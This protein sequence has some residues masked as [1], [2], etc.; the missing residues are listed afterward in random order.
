MLVRNDSAEG[1]IACRSSDVED[2][3]ALVRLIPVWLTTQAY[4]IPYAQYMTS[5]TKQGVTMERTIF[6]GV[7]IPPASLHVFIGISIV[8]FVPIYDGVF[9]PIARSITKDPC[10]I[11]TLKWNRNGTV[12]SH[13]GNCSSG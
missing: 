1:E 5:F 10:G 8:L 3:T 2:A 13:Y 6:P 7:K 9:V 12:S 11:T 4:A